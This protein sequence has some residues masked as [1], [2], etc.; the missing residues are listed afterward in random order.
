M[1]QEE[2]FKII[3]ILI[4][5]CFIIYIVMKILQPSH[6][7][8]Y[9]LQQGTIREGM[10]NGEA[11]TSSSYA[12]ELKAQVV[13]LQDELLVSKYRKDYETAIINLDDYLGYQMLKQALNMKTG[14]E[15]DIKTV[16]NLNILKN[17]RDSLDTAMTFL[18]KQ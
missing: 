14:D 3:G 6:S 13:K 1:R 10:T 11:G 2:L 15:L 16:N 9:M 18:D 8:M 7:N 5:S 4:V 17:A 12:A